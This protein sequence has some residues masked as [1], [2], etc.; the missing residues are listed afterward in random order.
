M[1]NEIV[2]IMQF[3]DNAVKQAFIEQPG[4][5]N[6]LVVGDK[7][8][9]LID[10]VTE[11][12]V[13]QS[14]FIALKNNGIEPVVMLMSKR[15]HDYASPPDIIVKAMEVADGTMYLTSTG[16][17][18]GPVGVRM[19]RLKKKNFFGEDLTADMM[20]RGM[21]WFDP[22]VVADWQ[23]WGRKIREAT[24]GGK[25]VHITSP[26]GTD[27]LVEVGDRPHMGTAGSTYFLSKVCNL[28]PSEAH[29]G[30][31]NINAGNGV[32]VADL[33]IHGIG[34][35]TNPI[36]LELRNGRIVNI[37]GSI[38]AVIFEEWLKAYGDENTRVLC[39]LAVGTNKW[40]RFT[41]S[42]RE[43]RK[44]WGTIHIG[45][46]QNL[47]VGGLIESNMHWDVVIN[48]A[49]ATVDGQ[50]IIKQGRIIL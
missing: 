35:I 28:G 31:P 2:H 25:L 43:D 8:I 37:E 6:P 40:A 4:N 16:L 5:N 44:I 26:S 42:L 12:S 10:D 18:H 11:A 7:I 1:G 24:V 30:L 50:E 14:F 20:S 9:I 45:F 49:S 34:K 33:S 32:I 39:E 38:D 27:L 29:L 48:N 47:D 3:A 15:K 21:K 23:G 22:E 19:S 46:G 36:T 41:G 17:N 13:W